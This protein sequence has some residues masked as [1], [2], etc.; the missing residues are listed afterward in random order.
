MKV[1]EAVR[2]LLE[3]DQNAD[4]LVITPYYP[5]GWEWEDAAWIEQEGDEVLI[6][7]AT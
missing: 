1:K 4:L 2:L 7:A 5:E 3:L 6:W